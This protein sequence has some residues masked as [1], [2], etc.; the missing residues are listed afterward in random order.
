MNSSLVCVLA[1]LTFIFSGCA[2]HAGSGDR[3]IP[4]GYH[5]ISVPIFKNK[6]PETG[7]EVYF[8]NSLI[9]E[10]ERSR[11]GRVADPEN[12]QVTLEG[13]ID[14]VKYVGAAENPGTT[15][16]TFIPNNTVLY[17]SYQIVVVANLV[18]KRNSDKKVLWQ[19]KFQKQSS[20]QTPD[21]GIIGLTGAN[22]LY[23]ASAHYQNIELLAADMMSEAHDRLTENF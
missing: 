17:T 14:S 1:A 11:V 7:I 15:D 16:Q 22:A 12:S 8:T 19:A 18:L 21:I 13:T 6:T 5:A 10:I 3:H 23:N 4:G 2:Y 9:R 20:Y